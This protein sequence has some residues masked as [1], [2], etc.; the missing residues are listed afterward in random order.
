MSDA[1]VET[2]LSHP[3]EETLSAYRDRELT[4]GER[5]RVDNHL[6]QCAACRRT[7]RE[8]EFFATQLRGEPEAVPSRLD[9][10][11]RERLALQHRGRG[12]RFLPAAGSLAA[13]AL[14]MVLASSVFNAVGPAPAAS[15]FPAPNATAVA[16]TTAVE[17]VYPSGIDKLAVE[18][19]VAIE[20]PVQVVKEWRGDTLVLKPQEPLQPNTTY[21]VRAPAPPAQNALPQLPPL[22]PVPVLTQAAPKPETSPTPAV[23]TSFTTAPVAVASAPSPAAA[24]VTPARGT[25]PAAAVA[26]ASPIATG[27]ALPPT[28]D[29]AVAPPATP[30]LTPPAAFTAARIRDAATDLADFLARREAS[31]ALGEATAP[32]NLVQ[33]TE[34]AFAGGKM[35]SRADERLVY[36][37]YRKGTWTGFADVAP[38]RDEATGPGRGLGLPTPGATGIPTAIPSATGTPTPAATP[39]ASDLA[40]PKGAFARIWRE[41]DEVRGALGESIGPERTSMGAMRAFANGTVLAGARRNVYV[42]YADGRWLEFAFVA[43]GKGDGRSTPTPSPT[44]AATLIPAP[45]PGG[46]AAT[47]T[48]AGNW[49]EV[50]DKAPACAVPVTRGF[51]IAYSE[52]LVEARLGCPVGAERGLALAEQAF[53]NGAMLWRSDTRAIYVLGQDGTWT[54]RQDTFVEG[55][56]MAEDSPPAGMLA[57]ARGFGKVWRESPGLRHSL[58]WAVAPERGFTGAAQEFAN[59]VMLWSDRKEIVILYADGHWERLPDRFAD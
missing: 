36:V 15:A 11:L 16:L 43:Q 5:S 47:P 21:S 2:P 52:P 32:A 39:A 12:W 8:Y 45:T 27:T 24:A 54:Q 3:T 31:L 9:W 7:L 56:E 49:I 1:N 50:A 6:A 37:L 28:R 38:A 51:G 44:P 58:G 22:P 25:M 26:L 46:T 18:S 10:E 23:I 4:P 41:R 30:A 35:L 34:Q 40:V 19:S 48:P 57:P 13:A 14:L 59:G 42:L 33:V 29:V 53:E 55:E 20:P 17:I